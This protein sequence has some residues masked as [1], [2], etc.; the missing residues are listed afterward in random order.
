[1]VRDRDDEAEVETFTAPAGIGVWGRCVAG[2]VG[3]GRSRVVGGGA[4]ER[5][6]ERA[7]GIDG[8]PSLVDGAVVVSAEE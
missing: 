5:V 1:M 3:A 4:A 7:V 6:V 8:P 2:L